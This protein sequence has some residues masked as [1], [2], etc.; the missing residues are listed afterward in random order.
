MK[1][2]KSFMLALS[3]LSA[4]CTGCSSIWCHA[5]PDLRPGVYAGT[6]EDA[7]LLARPEE[8]S[9]A[10]ALLAYPFI[11]AI[12]LPISAVIDTLLLPIDLPRQ[13]RRT[14]E[15]RVQAQ[16]GQPIVQ[17]I[18]AFREQTG[19]YPATL[20]DLAP[21]F[22]TRVPDMTDASHHKLGGWTYKPV[23]NGVAVSYN[24]VYFIGKGLGEGGFIEYDPPNWVVNDQGNRKVVLRDK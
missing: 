14:A 18:E 20:A 16:A 10:P 9:H 19:T 3:M 22:L 8:I 17:A 15:F 2:R 12:D 21:K 4:C 24:L 5:N 11:L 1:T 23:T 13:S 6:R 7:R